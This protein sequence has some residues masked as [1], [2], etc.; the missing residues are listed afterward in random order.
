[1]KDSFVKCR[2]GDEGGRMGGVC[3]ALRSV[4]GFEQFYVQSYLER[5]PVN[6]ELQGKAS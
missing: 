2:W 3:N 5:A 1:M 4:P 6:V